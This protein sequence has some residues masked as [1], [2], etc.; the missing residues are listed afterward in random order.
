MSNSAATAP[1]PVNPINQLNNYEISISFLL[2]NII[3]NINL[4]S[5]IVKIAVRTP[6]YSRDYIYALT[7]HNSP[8]FDDWFLVKE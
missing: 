1:I 8:S 6:V 3:F 4:E 5:L 2:N 7:R